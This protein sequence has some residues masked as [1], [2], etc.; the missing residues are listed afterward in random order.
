L[1]DPGNVGRVILRLLFRKFDVEVWTGPSWLRIG[2]GG[3][4][5]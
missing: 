2:K 4:H 5:M 1:G 3:G